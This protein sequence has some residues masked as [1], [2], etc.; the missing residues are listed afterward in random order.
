[1][2][3]KTSRALFIQFAKTPRLGRVKTRMQPQLSESQSLALHCRLVACTYDILIESALA[4]HE[5]WITEQAD[6][7]FFAGLKPQPKLV[8][9][10]GE[11]LGERMQYAFVEGLKHHQA[12]VLVGSDCPRLTKHLLSQA[13]EALQGGASCV[14]GPAFDGG[15]VLMGLTQT[16]E[17]LFSD[18]SWGSDQVLIQTRDR[19]R[20]LSWQ[21]EELEAQPD[22]D[23]PE[24]LVHLEGLN[25]YE[26]FILIY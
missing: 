20:Q 15:Y 5:L 19:L 11:N 9:Q 24:D 7:G 22:I 13:L 6:S 25:Q 16:D 14:L 26:E 2:K 17:L 3:A 18:V 12:V 23:R 4:S 8:M 21:W 1:M 10:Q